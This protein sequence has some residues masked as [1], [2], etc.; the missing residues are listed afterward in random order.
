MNE[1]FYDFYLFGFYLFGVPQILYSAKYGSRNCFIWQYQVI[2]W[3]QTIIVPIFL[4]GNQHN[5]L[6]LTPC[7]LN[8][9]VLPSMVVFQIQYSILQRIFGPRFGL[10]KC[11]F[12]REHKYRFS[13]KNLKNESK[14]WNECPICFCGL[15]FDPCDQI[16][17]ETG[18]VQA[19]TAQNSTMT[20]TTDSNA[21]IL[22][23][24]ASLNIK[25][26]KY[27]MKTPCKHYF[28]KKCLE[29]WM[30]VKMECPICRSQQPPL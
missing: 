22:S 13:I 23:T 3:S 24:E 7:P 14:D 16:I 15:D 27:C 20:L 9:I 8:L 10:L 18:S 6:R 25:K 30:D 21:H 1:L 2:F 4:K 19:E 17:E 5:F 29:Q 11:F 26:L 12:P 28:H